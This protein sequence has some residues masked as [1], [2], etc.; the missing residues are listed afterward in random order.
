MQY[1]VLLPQFEAHLRP[2]ISIIAE[3]TLA[4]LPVLAID[5]AICLCR[6]VFV[7]HGQQADAEKAV[8]F[9]QVAKRRVRV[10]QEAAGAERMFDLLGRALRMGDSVANGPEHRATGECTSVALW[11]LQLEH[12]T[13]LRPIR[14]GVN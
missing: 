1:D 7:A 10:G 6:A 13:V 4:G 3:R 2:S 14:Q 12:R 8:A 9:D 11:P 5:P